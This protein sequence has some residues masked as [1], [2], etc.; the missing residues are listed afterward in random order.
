M[1]MCVVVGGTTPS[2]TYT[3]IAVDTASATVH[4]YTGVSLGTASTRRTIFV[5]VSGGSS[6]TGVTIAGVTATSVASVAGFVNMSIWKADVPTGTTGTV[7]VA[8]SAA[9][10]RI[11][12]GVAAAYH[13][14]N[15]TATDTASVTSNTSNTLTVSV[16]TD[17]RGVAF[18]M[19]HLNT[20]DPS[21][22]ATWTGLTEG[23]ELTSSFCASVATA[24]TATAQ[25]PR[26]VVATWNHDPA[27]AK[28][29]IAASF[30]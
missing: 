2:I 1:A 6:T 5:G 12:I 21:P 28:G 20:L 23:G 13:L 3:D 8:Q 10:F 18:G 27:Y 9:D 26:S 29:A 17:A 14:R 15:S 24:N 4:T 16:N 7:V 25:T 30:S 11:F 19:A 22:N